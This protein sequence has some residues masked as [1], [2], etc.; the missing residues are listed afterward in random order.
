MVIFRFVCS[1][2]GPRPD[3]R[4]ASYIGRS[5]NFSLLLTL[6]SLLLV[7][8]VNP[9]KASRT[10]RGLLGFTLRDMTLVSLLD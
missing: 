9:L 6:L 10:P 7:L 8:M 3:W 2:F 5:L 1:G 4:G